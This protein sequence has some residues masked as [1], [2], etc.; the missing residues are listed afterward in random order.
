RGRTPVRRAFAHPAPIM[1]LVRV[2]GRE[3]GLSGERARRSIRVAQAGLLINAVLVVVK[4]GA[5]ILGRSYALIAD[6][7]ESSLDI[8]S[9][10][11]VWR[12]IHVASRSAD[13]SY[14]FGY[15]KA[16]SVAAAAVSLM[17]LG[18]AVGIAIEAVREIL[19][20]H[21]LPAPFTLVVLV[22]VV[23]I[24]ELLFRFVMREGEALESSIV[25]AD[26]WHHRSDAITSAAVFLGISIALIGGEPWAAADDAAALLASGIIAFNGLRLLRPALADLMDRAPEA[27][28]LE[29]VAEEAAREEGVLHI[30]KVVA[31]RAGVGHFVT[32]HVQAD[33]D[34]TLHDAHELGG[35][36]R[37]RIVANLPL[38]LDATIHMEPY[39]GY[40]GERPPPR[41]R[42][43]GHRPRLR[44]TDNDSTAY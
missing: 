35:R 3:R 13:E 11:I 38:V 32:V 7:V 12:G 29:S 23:A 2:R 16:E 30:E 25:Q 20:P 26:A 15:G 22:I 10:L 1:Y 8:F 41:G 17:L 6:G 40:A 27:E 4:I 18:A 36:V 33:P 9:S 37:S 24:K 39:E 28:L 21:H 44:E 34:L 42:L 31:R 5:G 14:H 43:S 19:T